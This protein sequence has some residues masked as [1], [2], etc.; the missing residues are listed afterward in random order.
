LRRNVIEGKKERERG[1]EDE[2]EE[3]SNYWMT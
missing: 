1:L 2:K 3:V